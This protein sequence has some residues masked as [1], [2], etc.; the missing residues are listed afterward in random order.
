M[1]QNKSITTNVPIIGMVCDIRQVDKST[2]HSTN[3][4]YIKA[5]HQ[6]MD[7]RVI[8][9]PC[10][11]DGQDEDMLDPLLD[12][13]DGVMLTGSPANVHPRF[14]GADATNQH[15]PF[16]HARDQTVLPLIRKTLARDMPL[17]AICRGFQEMNVACGGS[18]RAKIEEHHH[19]IDSDD[20][21]TVFAPRHRVDFVAGR[22]LHKLYDG[23]PNAM[24]N[25]LHEQGLDRL[26]NGLAVE[27]TDP[28]GLIE[29]ISV[30][31]AYFAI[32][33]QWH[34]EYQSHSNTT[35]AAL[36]TAFARALGF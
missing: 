18:L 8:L 27:A 6:Y 2:V 19:Q 23:A 36:Y 10:L 34:P 33:V 32:G 14:Y 15:P 11:L 20:R 13:V 22:T 25:S 24:V 35:S 17:L 9:I 1:P 12:L 5:V 29:A 30:S 21:D 28:D 3:M 16:D 7:A 26:G 31:D 4:R